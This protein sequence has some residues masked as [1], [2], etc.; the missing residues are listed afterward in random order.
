MLSEILLVN[1]FF[2]LKK[3]II[4]FG[5]LVIIDVSCF[6]HL[7]FESL[8]GFL[9]LLLGLFALSLNISLGELLNDCVMS[10]FF[11]ALLI[12]QDD[13]S[14][15][16]SPNTLGFLDKFILQFHFS[17]LPCFPFVDNQFPIIIDKVTIFEIRMN[18]CL[19]FLTI[20]IPL[21]LHNFDHVRW[22]FI[23]HL[24]QLLLIHLLVV[25]R[26]IF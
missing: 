10:I 13:F 25:I 21:L 26:C 1:L 2:L 9:L 14:G 3:S 20:G 19:H 16:E 4:S 8:F 11:C 15:Q 5:F 17:E 18:K 22:F 12:G 24:T 23:V 6:H 7:L